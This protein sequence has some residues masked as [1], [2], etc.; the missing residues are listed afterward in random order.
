MSQLIV[1]RF[2][3]NRNALCHQQSS[4]SLVPYIWVTWWF[5]FNLLQ[6]LQIWFFMCHCL[7][8]FLVSTSSDS[9]SH[10]HTPVWC[11]TY[12]HN[13]NGMG[14]F[15]PS[16]IQEN[17]HKICHM[18]HYISKNLILTLRHTHLTLYCAKWVNTKVTSWI[19]GQLLSC[20]A[21]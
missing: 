17:I 14:V 1:A 15:L 18:K 21:G 12:L 9:V 3:C 2:R 7:I 8:V 5:S 11:R 6:N 10:T 20:I 13:K 16:D 19:Q 4:S